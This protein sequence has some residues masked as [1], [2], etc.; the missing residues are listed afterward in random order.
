MNTKQMVIKQKWLVNQ[1]GML[2]DYD[3]KPLKFVI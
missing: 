3:Y 2:N 1:V